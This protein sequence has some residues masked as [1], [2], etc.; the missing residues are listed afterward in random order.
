MFHLTLFNPS[1]I[2][3]LPSV[4]DTKIFSALSWGMPVCLNAPTPL[5]T[6]SFLL[7][8]SFPSPAVLWEYGSPC[9]PSKSSDFL[10]QKLHDTGFQR[11]RCPPCFSLVLPNHLSPLSLQTL[12]YFKA[13]FWIGASHH[14]SVILEAV[15]LRPICEWCGQWLGTNEEGPHGSLWGAS[16]PSV[17]GVK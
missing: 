12:S 9:H 1:E 2:D 3:Y 15:T 13:N 6:N 7:F 4:S 8:P 5:H 16:E 11:G 17:L 10:L 14:A